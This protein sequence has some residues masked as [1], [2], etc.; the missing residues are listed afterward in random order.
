[1]SPGSS[2]P[3][4]DHSYI[5][6]LWIEGGT[7][8]HRLND[9]EYPLSR[10]D[11]WLIHEDDRHGF[12]GGEEPLV[13]MN[14]GFPR[15]NLTPFLETYYPERPFLWGRAP[16]KGKRSR[17]FTLGED[18][19]NR[20]SRLS[21]ELPTGEQKIRRLHRFLFELFHILYDGETGSAEEMPSW[22]RRGLDEL[23]KKENF[24]MGPRA[25]EEL[26][27]RSQ[28]HISRVLK[29]ATGLR[30][31]DMVIRARMAYAGGRLAFTDEEILAV[32][33]DTGY[34]SLGHFYAD[35]KVHFGRTP[36]EYR[37]EHRL[38]R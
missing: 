32:A 14:V 4:H 38:H 1:M 31:I 17:H 20:L 35:F 16:S 34:A 27:H 12:A 6:V 21:R 3:I 7:G 19:L 28:A 25:L 36:R 13:I 5:E 30:P 26:C 15:D 37:R 29:E 23:G 22:L 2:Y 9:G 24:L 33:L 11:L 8:S 10:G 18:D